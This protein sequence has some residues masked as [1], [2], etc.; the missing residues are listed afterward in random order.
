MRRTQYKTLSHITQL[1]ADFLFCKIRDQK[2]EENR[3]LWK[4]RISD[5]IPES[6]RPEPHYESSAFLLLRTDHYIFIF[7]HLIFQSI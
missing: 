4:A 7:I 3:L 5:D 1:K 2:S 6:S